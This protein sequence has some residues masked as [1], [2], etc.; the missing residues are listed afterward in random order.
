MTH[1]NQLF[2][3][4]SDNPFGAAVKSRGNAFDQRRDLSY[5]HFVSSVVATNLTGTEIKKKS[6]EMRAISV[7]MRLPLMDVKST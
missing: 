2:R 6:S 1:P 3:K 4:I 5:F 7:L